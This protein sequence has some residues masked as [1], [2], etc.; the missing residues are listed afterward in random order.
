MKDMQT[1]PDEPAPSE[2]TL[3]TIDSRFINVDRLAEEIAR[4]MGLTKGAFGLEVVSITNDIFQRSARKEV[5][6]YRDDRPHPFHSDGLESFYGGLRLT[7]DDADRLRVQYHG[8]FAQPQT[9]KNRGTEKKWTEEALE[10][11]SAYREKH[12]TQKTAETHNMSVARVRK[13]LPIEPKK[14]KPVGPWSGLGKRK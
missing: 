10:K 14:P 9:R 1:I 3:R 12:G 11:L 8:P 2:Q 4:S 6:L 5:Q 7:I 13:L